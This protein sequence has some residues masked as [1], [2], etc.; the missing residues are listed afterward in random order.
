M[1]GLEALG[2]A[3]SA[4]QLAQLGLAVA[5]SLTNLFSQIRDAPKILQTRLLQVQTLVELSRL[6]ASMPQLQMAEVDGI[7]QS[8]VRDA[9]DL[10]GVL[11]GLVVE[12][13]GFCIKK[14]TKVLGS[15]VMEKKIVGLLHNLEVG[16][17]ALSLCITRIDSQVKIGT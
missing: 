8:C 15:V 13:D 2:V 16:K 1:S 10:E 4:V 9:A 12:K 14:W 3:A 17:S 5:T 11:Q 6:I 7:L